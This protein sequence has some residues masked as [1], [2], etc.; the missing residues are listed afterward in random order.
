MIH[1]QT[2]PFYQSYRWKRTRAKILRR[3]GYMCQLSKRYGKTIPADTVHHIFPRLK[4]PQ[5][6]WAEW[7]L[8]SLSQTKHDELHNRMTGELTR[9]GMALL[10]RTA[11][12]KGIDLNADFS[13]RA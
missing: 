12:K 4:Y 8:I 7:N 2:D 10:E 1:K 5:Y 11:R 3:D 6:Q 13:L 9:E